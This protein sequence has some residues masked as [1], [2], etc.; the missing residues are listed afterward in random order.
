VALYALWRAKRDILAERGAS[1]ELEVL[2]DFVDLF[3]TL[4]AARNWPS[5]AQTYLRLIEVSADMPMSR[6]A[7]NAR[8]SREAMETYR[9]RYPDAPEWPSSGFDMDAARKRIISIGEKQLSNELKAAIEHR[10]TKPSKGLPKPNLRLRKR[11]T[12]PICRKNEPATSSPE[13]GGPIPQDSPES[14]F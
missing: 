11:P 14:E 8:P 9:A 4:D 12:K 7:L 10:I 5:R 1:H 2:R 13:P 3:Q 6:A